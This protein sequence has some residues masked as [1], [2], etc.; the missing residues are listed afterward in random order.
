MF[1]FL[2]INPYL[3]SIV[4][5]AFFVNEWTGNKIPRDCTKGICDWIQ[6]RIETAVMH[7]CN[8][9]LYSGRCISYNG[10]KQILHTRNR[11]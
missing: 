5:W 3:Y 10:F 9:Y 4:E 11:S 6:T 7:H 8:F 2:G 1:A